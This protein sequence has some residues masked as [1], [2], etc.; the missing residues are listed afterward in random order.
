MIIIIVS[1]DLSIRNT[2]VDLQADCAMQLQES[3]P[4]ERSY[5]Y[6]KTAGVSCR[7]KAHNT[8][9]RQCPALFFSTDL[10]SFTLNK[11]TT[12]IVKKEWYCQ[13]VERFGLVWGVVDGS[14]LSRGN[15]NTVCAVASKGLDS[16][17]YRNVQVQRSRFRSW[18]CTDWLPGSTRVRGCY[19]YVAHAC[20]TVATL[21][22]RQRPSLTSSSS[23]SSSTFSSCS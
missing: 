16:R 18:Q 3:V 6:P 1:T 7:W 21:R 10:D 17:L 23:S 12:R 9:T 2:I 22:R 5:I 11:I 4:R 13:R 8:C 19:F 20:D 14:S 15:R